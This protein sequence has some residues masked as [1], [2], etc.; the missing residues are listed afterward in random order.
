MK[1]LKI[2]GVEK[3]IVMEYPRQV[4]TGESKG[5]ADA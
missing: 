2:E 5:S 4:C 3:E 1:L